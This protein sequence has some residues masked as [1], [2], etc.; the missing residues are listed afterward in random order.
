MELETEDTLTMTPPQRPQELQPRTKPDLTKRNVICKDGTIMLFSTHPH[1]SQFILG[2]QDANNL[3]NFTSDGH[4]R[5][6]RK[7]EGNIEFWNVFS[8]DMTYR[9]TGEHGKSCRLNM[10]ASTTTQVNDWK[11]AMNKGYIGSERDLKNQEVTVIMRVHKRMGLKTGCC[12]KMRGGGHHI[13]RP[14]QAACIELDVSTHD[15]GH[16]AR[17]T[18]ELFHPSYEYLELEPLFDFF[19][20]EGRWFGMKTTS[21]NNNNDN[22]PTTNKGY[23][24]PEPFNNDGTLKN[25]CRLYSEQLK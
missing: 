5:F 8:G 13:D 20:E 18:K 10:F 12:I 15:S 23:I 24:D 14:E 19:L 7:K 11:A 3:T 1:G 21:W 4:N 6:I 17:W 16:S 9:S 25:D 22:S 2:N